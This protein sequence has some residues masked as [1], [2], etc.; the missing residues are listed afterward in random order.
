MS[1][2]GRRAASPCPCF[3]GCVRLSLML[4]GP[5]WPHAALA[6]IG[7]LQWPRRQIPSS[8]FIKWDWRFR[9]RLARRFGRG[10]GGLTLVFRPRSGRRLFQVAQCVSHNITVPITAVLDRKPLVDEIE[11]HQLVLQVRLRYL[12]RLALGDV[13][14][15]PQL[16]HQPV[17]GFD[18][19]R[20][21]PLS[22]DFQSRRSLG[23]KAMGI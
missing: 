5:D 17:E 7:L 6:G 18:P 10:V 12:F 19:A 16:R 8:S 22:V 3:V 9:V 15:F 23:A 13:S 11:L 20:V 21:I 4:P 14:G 2:R 1:L